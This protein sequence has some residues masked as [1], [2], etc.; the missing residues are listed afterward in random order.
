MNAA[1]RPVYSPM[2][3]PGILFNTIKSGIAVDY[4]V[5]TGSFKRTRPADGTGGEQAPG[6]VMMATASVPKLDSKGKLS[7]WHYRVPFEASLN[8]HVMVA[9]SQLFVRHPKRIFCPLIQVRYTD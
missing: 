6:Y 1:R 3:S 9:N 7:G 5:Y 4:P 8:S 2:F